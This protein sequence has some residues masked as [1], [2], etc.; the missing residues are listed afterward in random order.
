MTGLS[1]SGTMCQRT[2]R[3]RM[4]GPEFSI[5]LERYHAVYFRNPW[6]RLVSCYRDKIGGEV[7]DFTDFS[8]SGVAHR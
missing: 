8:A 6:D 2:R 4:S 3:P 1:P 7:D 5:F